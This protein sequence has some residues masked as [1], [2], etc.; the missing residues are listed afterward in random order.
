[1]T[2][3]LFKISLNFL[4]LLLL[5]S[6]LLLPFYFAKNFS[7]VSG[8]KSETPYL[9]VSQVEK[10]PGMFLS[11]NGNTYEISLEKQNNKQ[12]YLSVLVVNNPTEEARTYSLKA[13][14]GATT[15]FFGEDINNPTTEIKVP[16]KASVPVSLLSQGESASTQTIE[17]T[18][19]AQ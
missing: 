3:N 19:E 9:I 4:A 18:I 12:A 14:S 1:M 2:I 10:F 6:L 15:V 16:Q 5:S 13:S 17:F 11:Q 7:Q 8:V